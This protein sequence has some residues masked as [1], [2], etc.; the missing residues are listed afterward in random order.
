[1]MGV[2]VRRQ[3]VGVSSLCI[4][5]VPGIELGPK[6]SPTVSF[7]PGISVLIRDKRLWL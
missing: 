5:W 7:C 3:S 1:M 6:A 4:T 2:E